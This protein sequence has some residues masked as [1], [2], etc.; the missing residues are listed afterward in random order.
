MNVVAS[1]LGNPALSGQAT[2]TISVLRNSAAPVFSQLTFSTSIQQ[3]VGIGTSVV[4]ISASDADTQVR[5][6]SKFMDP[7]LLVREEVKM[8]LQ[9]KLNILSVRRPSIVFSISLNCVSFISFVKKAFWLIVAHLFSNGI[10]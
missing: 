9:V 3:T 6:L 2:L 8:T 1:D 5:R 7:T 10:T 4:L